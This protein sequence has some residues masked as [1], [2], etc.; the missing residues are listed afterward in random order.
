MGT[1]SLPVPMG[2]VAFPW[3]LQLQEELVRHSSDLGLLD[4]PQLIREK[5]TTLCSLEKVRG[6]ICG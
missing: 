1:P 6:W 4:L 2:D 3:P 5:H